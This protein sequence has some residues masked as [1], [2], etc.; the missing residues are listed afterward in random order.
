[1]GGNELLSILIQ[2]VKS[3]MTG[4]ITKL[5]LYTSWGFIKTKIVIKIRDFFTNL[6]AVRFP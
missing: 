1:M 4:F 5:R 2:T 6:L 3:K